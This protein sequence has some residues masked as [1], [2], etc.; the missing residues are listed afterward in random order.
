[1]SKFQKQI[2]K[3]VEEMHPGSAF[4]KFFFSW[5]QTLNGLFS[6]PCFLKLRK[7]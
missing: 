7:W 2:L 5:P 4:S 3:I 1:M 6:K